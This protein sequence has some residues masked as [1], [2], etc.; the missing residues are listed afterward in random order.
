M[1]CTR[2]IDCYTM[3]SNAC[4]LGYTF[5][6]QDRVD[7]Y[8]SRAFASPQGGSANSHSIHDGYM[9]VECKQVEGP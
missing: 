1:H 7:G 4:P 3:A 9:M 5:V 8:E 2:K 6:D